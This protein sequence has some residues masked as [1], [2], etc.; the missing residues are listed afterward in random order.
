[1]ELHENEKFF[2][3][4]DRTIWNWD[5]M[6]PGASDL[7]E[8]IRTTG[9]E[10]KFHTDNTLLSRK[11]YADKLTEMGF[12]T[13]E[14]DVLTSGYVLAEELTSNGVKEV[15]VSGES[16]LITELQEKEITI[17]DEAENAVLGFDRSFSYDKM[18]KIFNI[19]QKEGEVFVCST[20]RT[21]HRAKK[22]QP[23]QKTLNNAVKG[24]SETE[25]VG[26]PSEIYK[27]RFKRYFS[28]F[29]GNSAF[30]GDRLEDIETGNKL[31]ITTALV[32][33]GATDHEELKN[34]KEE[35]VP[36]YAITDLDKLRRRII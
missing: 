1:M 17:S 16:G 5:E 35:Q 36:D 27:K 18:Q 11:G 25:L 31:G 34:A 20:E 15:Y 4:L 26:K 8:T 29:P 28:Y 12:Q 21:F 3:D 14:E 2:I 10:V 22:I 23:H 6:K 30:I 24:F 33:N 13:D 32:M 9:K 7:L 19:A